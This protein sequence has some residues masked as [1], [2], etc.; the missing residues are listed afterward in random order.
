MNL[1]YHSSALHR[2]KYLT[3]FLILGRHY[4]GNA[5]DQNDS[6]IQTWY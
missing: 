6:I 1:K 4:D 3:F 5:S 2:H